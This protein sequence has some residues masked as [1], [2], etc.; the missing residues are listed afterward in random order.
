MKYSLRQLSGMSRQRLKEVFDEY[1][2]HVY[3]QYFKECGLEN[4]GLYDT[5]LLSSLGLPPQASMPDIKKRFRELAKQYHPDMG[6]DSALFIQLMEVYE[7]LTGD[8]R[9]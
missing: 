9:S 3:F 1:F 6:G 7:R 2:Y 5:S 8:E 4:P